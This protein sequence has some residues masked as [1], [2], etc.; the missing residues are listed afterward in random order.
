MIYFLLIINHIIINSHFLDRPSLFSKK[1]EKKKKKK[2]L[3]CLFFY[4]KGIK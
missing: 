3:F 4:K 1:N 2:K